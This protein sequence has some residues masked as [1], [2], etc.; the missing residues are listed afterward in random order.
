[1][2]QPPPL[3]QYAVIDCGTNTF[4]LLIAAPQAD[5]SFRE[6]FRERQFVKLAENGIKRIG[7]K[8]Y[9]RALA[10][11]RHYATVIDQH[12]VEKV[13]VSGTAALRTADN[14][15][16]FVA[17]VLRETGLEICTIPG[18]EE[19]QLIY[20]GV[21]RA[22]GPMSGRWMVMDIGGGSVEFI[23]SDQEGV[24]WFK[25]FPVGVAVTYRDFHRSEPITIE[26]I[27]ETVAFLTH[28]LH[29]LKEALQRFPT[30][31]LIG[32]AGTFD[33]IAAQL[34]ANHPTPN[35]TAIELGQ[36]QAF[37]EK[38]V[39]A[40]RTERYAMT[41]IHDDRADMIVVALILVKYILELAQIEQLTVSNFSMKEGMLD[42][43]SN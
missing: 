35:S 14:G 17:Q 33:V 43:M 40:T 4:H 8:P 22:I 2:H 20:R 9:Q 26:E 34:G 6:I 37:Y 41:H 18:S 16:A 7:E 21:K 3:P 23:I 15:P 31:H 12:Q 10:A 38:I 29:D 19:A 39:A 1:M 24:R 25:S 11:L 30:K 36:F 27:D 32:A 28:E 5:G 42:A 13:R